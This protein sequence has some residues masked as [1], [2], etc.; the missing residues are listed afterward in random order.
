[1]LEGKSKKD[2]TSK[3]Y[4]FPTVAH[5]DVIKRDNL[6]PGDCVST[7][8]F[9]CRIKGCL[10][11]SRSKE[12]PQKMYCGGTVFAGHASAVIKTF[13]QVSLGASYTIR[14]KELNELWD[15]EY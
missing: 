3:Q 11:S 12:D 8:Q 13:N 6:L 7:D 2:I 10:P 5:C 9:E 1:M 4:R 15:S 14:S